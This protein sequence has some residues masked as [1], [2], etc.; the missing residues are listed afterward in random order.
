MHDS[1]GKRDAMEPM[2]SMTQNP[3][4]I[5]DAGGETKELVILKH[6][7]LVKHMALRLFSRLPDHVSIDDLISAGVIGLI[8]A[9]DKYDSGQGI[10]FK[11][12]AKIRIRGAMLDEI[13]AMDWVPRS[14][15]QKG[16]VLERT[17]SALE[18]KLGRCPSDEQVAGELNIGIEDYHRLLDEIKGISF[19]PENINEALL[20]NGES[21]SLASDSEELFQHAYRQEIQ[22][23]LADA[24]RTLTEKEQLVLS[25]YYY[26]ELTMKEVGTALGYT[27]SRI[28]QIHTKAIIKLRSR[29]AKRLTADDLPPYIGSRETCSA[30]SPK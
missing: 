28:S 15:R 20:E 1:A 27:E 11:F 16:N 14:L 19:L 2:R 13:R 17:F 21:G 4:P 7:D 24:I 8:D 22:R 10:P 5:E 25:L 23:H 30:G 3:C 26:D 9:V 18:Q 29:L 6:S 12:Y